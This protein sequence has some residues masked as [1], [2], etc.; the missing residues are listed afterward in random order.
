[1][2]QE[3]WPFDQRS[4]PVQLARLAPYRDD[5]EAVLE[6]STGDEK[7]AP[8]LKVQRPDIV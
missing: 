4:L 2:P 6:I 8:P 1:V 5:I 3:N 7:E